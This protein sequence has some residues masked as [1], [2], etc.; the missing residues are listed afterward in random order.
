MRTLPTILLLLPLL[1]TLTMPAFASDGVLEINQ[2]CATSAGGCFPGD[3][4]GW[5][6]TIASRGSYRLTGNLSVPLNTT[7]IQIDSTFVTVDLGGFVV[8][9]QNTCAGYP[10]SG[11][12]SEFGAPGINSIQ[13]LVVVRN[14]SV[15]GMSGDCIHLG[16]ASSEA[17][18]VRVLFC[19]GNAGIRMGAAGR[20]SHSFSGANL[21]YGILMDD[22]GTVV[23]NESRANG[24]TGLAMGGA[25]HGGSLIQNVTTDNRG[26]GITADSLILVS[27]NIATG[28]AVVPHIS[29]G[30]SLGD[31]LCAATRC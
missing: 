13:Y 3:A 15:T 19:G 25:A 5:P 22:G 24:S 7:A 2:A 20:V 16:G 1:L 18:D 30:V 12:T 8:D 26:R 27:R 29:G 21:N 4:S 28:N 31:N 10:V 9:G 14:G 17:A 23:D 6:V 11:C